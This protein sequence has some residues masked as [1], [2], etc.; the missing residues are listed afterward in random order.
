MPT[1][2]TYGGRQVRS[3]N[4][5]GQISARATANDFGA[6]IGQGIQNVGNAMSQYAA[7]LKAK[8]D[9]ARVKEATNVFRQRLNERTYLDEDAFYNRKGID[10]YENYEPFTGEFE[11]IKSQIAE[12]LK[13]NRQKEMFG[14]IA[15]GYITQEAETMSRHAAKERTGWLN[16]QDEASITQAQQDGVLRY[17]DNGIYVDQIRKVT[18]NLQARNGWSGEEAEVYANAQI[19]NLHI[20]ALDSVIQKSP[21]AARD[22]FETHKDSI[23]PEAYDEIEANIKVRE[24]AYFVQTSAQTIMDGGGTRSERLAMVKELTDDPEQRKMLRAQVQADFMQEQYAKQ[25][26]AAAAYESAHEQLFDPTG[27]KLSFPE[28]IASNKDEW[29]A[30]EKNMQDQI[31]SRFSDPESR[32]ES[33]IFVYNEARGMIR[34]DSVTPQQAREFIMNAQDLSFTDQRSLLKEI[35][36]MASGGGSGGDEAG[37]DYYNADA[38]REFTDWIEATLGKRPTDPDDYKVWSKQYNMAVG[39]FANSLTEADNF[40]SRRQLLDRMSDDYI[41]RKNRII[42]KDI[43]AK[44]MFDLPEETIDDATNELDSL[45]IEMDFESVDFYLK[46]GFNG[47]QESDRVDI[48]NITKALKARNIDVTL[49]TVMAALNRVRSERT[50]RNQFNDRF[51]GQ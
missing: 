28:Y 32:N 10:A 41:A 45:G 49:S 22:Y 46:G 5:G 23:A 34:N 36:A 11:K 20:N 50:S 51:G 12:G 30:L 38:R 14:Q 26:A 43:P 29:D 31:M 37:K 6:S 17:M 8:D 48:V 13:G 16:G 35:D 47:L 39:V 3:Q 40:D 25:E 9:D 27:P 21:A 1:I 15:T 18:A 33:D 24:D 2:K 44:S 19:S 4:I 42:R 7:E